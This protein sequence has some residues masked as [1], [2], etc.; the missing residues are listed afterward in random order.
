MDKLVTSSKGQ[1]FVNGT[2]Y[3]DANL[4]VALDLLV[5]LTEW[6]KLFLRAEVSNFLMLNA[7]GKAV[8]IL[9][10]EI[11]RRESV[12][13]DA[14]LE[15]VLER[16]E[17]AHAKLVRCCSSSSTTTKAMTPEEE[18]ETADATK[19]FQYSLQTLY[20]YMELNFGSPLHDFERFAAVMIAVAPDPSE[21]TPG[22]DKGLVEKIV[23]FLTNSNVVVEREFVVRFAPAVQRLLDSRRTYRFVNLFPSS[24]SS[25]PGNSDGE[26]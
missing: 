13:G 6:D 18:R 2:A 19:I 4:S 17:S 7:V 15:Y 24:S 5:Q 11:P 20:R 16:A 10:A 21:S 23:G 1:S 22:T 3:G 26:K 9:L 25:A 8:R 14:I 12:R